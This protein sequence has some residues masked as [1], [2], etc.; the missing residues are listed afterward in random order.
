M[1]E[2]IDKIDEF[3]DR[4]LITNRNTR[5]GYR[6]AI[7]TF[8]K[9]TGRAIDDYFT[10][11]LTEQDYETDLT[12][13]YLHFEKMG[14]PA[15]SMRT[16]INPVKQFMVSNNKALKELEFWSTFS[17]RIRGAEPYSD[18]EPMNRDS[19]K[20][21]LQHGDTRSRAL[22]LILA[23]SGR[24]IGEILALL[25]ED[26][27]TEVSPA[28]INIR[29]T[30]G[31]RTTKTRMKTQAYISDEAMSAYQAWMKER[32]SYLTKASKKHWGADMDDRRVF[33]FTI[34]TAISVWTNL[35]IKAEVVDYQYKE[36]PKSGKRHKVAKRSKGERLKQH[37]HSLRK[38]F[39]SYLGNS[40]LAE[41]LMGHAT[42]MTRT[43][44]QMTQEDIAKEYRL[45]MPNV[46]IFEVPVDM[47]EQVEQVGKLNAE[48][49]KMQQELTDL[50]T[51]IGYLEAKIKFMA[52]EIQDGS[53]V[54]PQVNDKEEPY[55]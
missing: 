39:R 41:Y 18:E 8:F 51:K 23:S 37:P 31:S 53:F 40:D 21:I 20:R 49:R 28:W 1:G 33:P 24:R 17:S 32:Q 34:A 36:D 54:I 38:F 43:Y 7:N 5:N 11:R 14:K 55:E 27:H 35:L 12:R 48:N 29:K 25:P 3:L 50:Y 30:L 44:R 22:F 6:I 13:L 15:L 9:V 4:R 2:T 46:T 26:V 10:R 16:Y 42:A 52:E 47:Q 19:I 45:L